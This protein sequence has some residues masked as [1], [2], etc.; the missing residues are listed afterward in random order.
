MSYIVTCTFH[1]ESASSLNDLLFSFSTKR[2]YQGGSHFSCNSGTLKMEQGN[3]IFY[4]LPPFPLSSGRAG[5]KTIPPSAASS[6]TLWGCGAPE[7]VIIP[8]LKAF[9]LQQLLRP[10]AQGTPRPERRDSLL[11]MDLPTHPGAAPLTVRPSSSPQPPPGNKQSSPSRGMWYFSYLSRLALYSTEDSVALLKPKQTRMAARSV[12]LH[13][14][15]RP[16]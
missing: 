3:Q 5:K 4:P 9:L 8:K 1:L 14:E 13:D 15:L 11:T 2:S 7:H 12:T 10:A 16:P 6:N